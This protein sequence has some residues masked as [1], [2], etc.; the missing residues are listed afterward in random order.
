MTSQRAIVVCMLLAGL[1]ACA[2]GGADV[3]HHVSMVSQGKELSDL[4][5]ALDAGAINQSEYDRLRNK[6]LSRGR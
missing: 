6:V 4:K 2:G 1:S 5:L 3:E